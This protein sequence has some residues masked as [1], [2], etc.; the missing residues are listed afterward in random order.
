MNP[1]NRLIRNDQV[2]VLYSPG[3]GAGWSTWNPEVPELLFDPVIVEFVEKDQWDELKVY[4][5]LKYPGLYDGGL[6]DLEVKW[7]PVG[8]AFRIHDF[9]GS[10]SIQVRDQVAWIIA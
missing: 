3:F 1:I 9:D 7:L 10:E 6:T 4:V 5:A 2:A 8:T